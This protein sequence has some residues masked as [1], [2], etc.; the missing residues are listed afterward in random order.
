M[1]GMFAGFRLERGPGGTCVGTA[2]HLHTWA[3][4][5]RSRALGKRLQEPGENWGGAQPTRVQIGEE[6]LE[7]VPETPD[8]VSVLRRWVRQVNGPNYPQPF[9]QEGPP[10]CFRLDVGDAAERI[11]TARGIQ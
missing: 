10:G 2:R 1:P 7:L 9:L 8:Q 6:C 4:M 11:R 5:A 3:R